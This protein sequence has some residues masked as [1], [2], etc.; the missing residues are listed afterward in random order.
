MWVSALLDPDGIPGRVLHAVRDRQ[1]RPIV[2]WELAD[3]LSRV[4][5]RPKLERYRISEAN[6]STILS[7]VAPFLPTVEFDLAPRD[8]GD[9]PVIAAAIGGNA[10]IICTGDRDLLDD[11]LLRAGLEARGI[12]VL[13]PAELVTLLAG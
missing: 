4:I 6:L 13:R 8:P 2:T 5:R 11:Q 9:L 12:R 7:L 10:E 1:I 3:E